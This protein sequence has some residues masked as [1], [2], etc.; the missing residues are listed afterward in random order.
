LKSVF[1]YG[2]ERGGKIRGTPP[3]SRPLGESER[4]TRSNDEPIKNSKS[5]EETIL[6]IRPATTSY[7]GRKIKGEGKKGKKGKQPFRQER[8]PESRP[9]GV[10][11]TPSKGR[12]IGSPQKKNQKEKPARQKKERRSYKS[13]SPGLRRFAENPT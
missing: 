9:E 8:L 7:R 1:V 5:D 10:P 3:Q 2:A 6:I 11:A 13:Q 12:G 4:E